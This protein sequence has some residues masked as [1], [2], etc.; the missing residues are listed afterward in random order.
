MSLSAED[1]PMKILSN[2]LTVYK[3][4]P[5]PFFFMKLQRKN[6]LLKT[7]RIYLCTISSEEI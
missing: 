1:V 3:R 5:A 6:P 2:A 4:K 7:S